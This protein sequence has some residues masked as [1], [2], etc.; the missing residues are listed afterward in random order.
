MSVL[1]LSLNLQKLYYETKIQQCAE[2]TKIY[3]AYKNELQAVMDAI[4]KYNDN[5][6]KIA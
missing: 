4:T 3:T 6:S 1:P 2:G 5:Q